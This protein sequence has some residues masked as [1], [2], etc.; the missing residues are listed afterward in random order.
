VATDPAASPRSYLYVPADRP[1]KFDRAVGSAADALILDL[2]DSVA[3][4]RKAAAREALG[5]WLARRRPTARQLWVRI[6][7]EEV[8]ADIA[9]AVTDAVTGVVVPKAEPELLE[10]VDR[11]LSTHSDRPVGLIPLIETARGL[12]SV[13]R[14]ATASRVQRLGLGEVD[15][16]AEL[17]VKLSDSG[18]ELDPLRL[19]IVLACAGARISPPVGSTSRDFRDLE[20]L[21]VST[22]RLLRLGFRARTMIHP[23]QAAV[24]NDVFTP[25]TDEVAEASRI[26]QDFERAQGE[27]RGAGT[28]ADGTMIDLAVVRSAR[29]VIARGRRDEP[30]TRE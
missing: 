24:V 27:G 26:V 11:V 21:R 17:G 25:T 12:L 14:V 16:S 7:P 15:L 29:D 5:E 9:A 22:T 28:G 18:S 3:P 8:A 1:T 2:E 20:S 4:N 13:D 30:P 19:R 23:A 6:N 10:E